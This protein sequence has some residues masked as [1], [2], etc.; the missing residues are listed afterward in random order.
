MDTNGSQTNEQ[1][2]GDAIDVGR[3]HES[4]ANQREQARSS[5]YTPRYET[6]PPRRPASERENAFHK[7]AW[8][9]EGATGIV[10]EVLHNDL[11]LTEDFWIHAYAA[12]RES[13]L[14]L[15]AIVDTLVDGT[16]SESGKEAERQQRRERRGGIEI[17]F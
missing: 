10:E 16:E 14:A 7:L 8:L 12:R 17:D 13:L 3:R 4:A 9:L 5:G 15:Q 1:A 2:N 11:G 6:P